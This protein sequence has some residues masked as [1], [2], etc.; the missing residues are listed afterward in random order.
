MIESLN[1]VLP[2]GKF[3]EI[4]KVDALQHNSLDIYNLLNNISYYFFDLD[5][6]MRSKPELVYKWG[7]KVNK[8]LC[9]NIIKPPSLTIYSLNE[10]SDALKYLGAS[11]HIGKVLL[12]YTC[13]EDLYGLSFID[14]NSE[15]NNTT[16]LLNYYKSLNNKI[17]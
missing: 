10:I 14:N 11:K 6:Y 16:L 15:T 13:I 12:K 8:M 3:I 17:V 1:L 7:M 9:N 4:G 2:F 5:R